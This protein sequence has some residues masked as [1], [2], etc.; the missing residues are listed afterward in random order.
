MSPLNCA[1]AKLSGW[2]GL[3]GA[4]RTELC[5]VLFGVDPP[6]Q[7]TVE[8]AGKLRH[9]LKRRARPSAPV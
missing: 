1:P 2:P 9:A 5:R 4:G 6:E 3:M 7:G 8:I